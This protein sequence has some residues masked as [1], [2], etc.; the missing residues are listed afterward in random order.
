MAKIQ[1]IGHAVLHVQDLKRS[2]AFYRDILG[3]EE[4]TESERFRGCFLS[5]GSRDHDLALFETGAPVEPRGVNHI[6]FKLDGGIED[7]KAFHQRLLDADVEVQVTVDHAIS[8]GV[9]FLD[10]DGHCL[11]V[12]VERDRPE[13]SRVEAMRATGVVAD[14]IDL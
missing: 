12:F 11:E 4:V 5:F 10:P 6:A 7:L 2:R 8:Y 9:Y 14:P 3:M 1:E 13:A